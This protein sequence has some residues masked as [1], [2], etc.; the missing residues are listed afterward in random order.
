MRECHPSGGLFPIF[1]QFSAARKSTAS[2]RTATLVALSPPQVVPL[3]STNI[4]D[5]RLLG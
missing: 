1:H 4:V 2:L 5:W 3:N